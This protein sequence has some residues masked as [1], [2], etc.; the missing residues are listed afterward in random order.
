MGYSSEDCLALFDTS[1][2]GRMNPGWQSGV[3]LQRSK[4]TTAGPMVYC[5][6]YPIWL[7]QKQAT[8]ARTELQKERQREAQRKLNEKNA[9][10]KLIRKINANFGEGD[11]L[12]TA[13]YP[14]EGQPESD[15]AAQR[16][17][18]N[19]L[20][21]VKRMRGKKGLPDLRYI[22]ITESTHSEK[23]GTRYHHHVIM[24]GDGMSREEIEECWTRKHGGLCNT[25][26]C[27]YQAK[28]LSGFAAYMT[29]GKEQR[30]PVGQKKA[31]KRR[32]SCSKNLKKPRETVA[33]KKI[34]VR[35]AGRIAEAMERDAREIFEKLYPDCVL[36]DYEVRR[37]EWAAGV[38]IYA[39]LRKKKGRDRNETGQRALH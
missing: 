8:A 33:D 2:E 25:R 36:L 11:I 23:N 6:S 14:P 1:V 9:R 29:I 19:M 10:K 27:Q 24:S 7:T 30:E 4:T 12:F 32:W 22:Y 28:H 35:K 3:I 17:M 20:A 16:D 13:T 26:R 18:R 31:M 15:E 5:E 37:S 21:R 38:Y 39:E 34:S